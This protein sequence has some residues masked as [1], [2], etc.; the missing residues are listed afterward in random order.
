MKKVFTLFALLLTIVIGAK[1]QDYESYDW[2]SSE[3]IAN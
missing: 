2:A 1:A 3:E